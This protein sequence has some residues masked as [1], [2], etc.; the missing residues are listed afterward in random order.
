MTAPSPVAWAWRRS[1]GRLGRALGRADVELV[2]RGELNYFLASHGG[3]P[4]R[5]AVVR[6]RA[7]LPTLCAAA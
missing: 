2:G 6:P 7:V 3:P 5:V 4:H 1:A